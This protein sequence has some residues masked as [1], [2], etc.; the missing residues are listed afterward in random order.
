MQ[1]CHTIVF[2]RGEKERLVKEGVIVG[3]CKGCVCV[4]AVCVEGC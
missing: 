2:V 1:C 3:K 4:C